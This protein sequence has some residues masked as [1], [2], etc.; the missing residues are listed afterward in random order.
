MFDE[1]AKNMTTAAWIVAA[2]F[3]VLNLVLGWLG[4]VLWQIWK[5][6]R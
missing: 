4:W 6:D 2:P 3:W 5:G 1:L